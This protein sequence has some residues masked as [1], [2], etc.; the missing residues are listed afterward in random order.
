MQNTGF[1]GFGGGS[2]GGQ[3]IQYALPRVS[4]GDFSVQ[5]THGFAKHFGQPQGV[6]FDLN[7]S[8][9]LYYNTNG[10]SNSGK[11]FAEKALDAWS[12]VTGI[13]FVASNSS[14]ADIRFAQSDTSGAYAVTYINGSND[15]V[16]A[17]V[18]IPSWWIS[19]DD[20][21]LNSYSYQTYLHE[22]GHA[23][24]LGHAGNYN[25]S[26]TFPQDAKFA[27]DSWQM[28]V[29][30]YFSQTENPNVN[31]SHAYVL[32]PMAADII[33]MHRLYGQP[34]GSDRVNTGNTIWGRDSNA[35]GPASEFS[36]LLP[37]M[38][39]TIYDQGGI[40]TVDFSNTGKNQNIDLRPG[41][42]S[43]VYGKANNV[44]IE[45]ATFIENA[46]GGSGADKIIGNAF[47][48]QLMGGAGS[49]S[50]FGL[51]GADRLFGD[52]GWDVIKGGNGSDTIYG[53]DGN[54][55]LFGEQGND[56]VQGGDG[57]DKIYGGFGIDE[58]RGGAGSDAIYGQHDVDTIF[59]DTGWDIIRGGNGSDTIYGGDGNDALLGERG[60]DV[61]H[62]GEGDDKILG[63]FDNDT[64]RGD[65]GAD[66]IYGEHGIDTIYGGADRDLISGGGGADR[67][68][69][70]DGNDALIGNSGNDLISGGDGDD[71]MAGGNGRDV[72]RGGAGND[73]LNGEASGDR[74]NGGLGH[75]VLIG[76]PGGDTF[77][78]NDGDDVIWDFSDAQGDLLEIDSSLVSTSNVASFLASNAVSNGN[79]T[80][81]TFDN[82]DTLTLLG[83]TDPNALVDDIFFF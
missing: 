35:E 21:N 4:P 10:I 60:H 7:A 26:A 34:S 33:A 17:D 83:L 55:A 66:R 24:G 74:L 30:S 9:T 41:Y 52:Q 48:N 73:R 1:L 67:I 14:F 27:N 64:L 18:N 57:K 53:Q 59:G 2:A 19:G 82:G 69:G 62:G 25:G 61:I 23:L 68:Y 44:H 71:L 51:H 54:D 56:V 78:F 65:A 28:S 80:T 58:L 3:Q 63:G 45:R 76:G 8:R 81:I 75:D 39:M 15:I 31:A 29:M 36:S 47:A 5:L 70:D 6:S 79:N 46:T 37:A 32:T 12:A 43:S 77:I 20:Y 13:A 50:I 11:W 72:L 16:R 49:D 22:I 40:D 42:F 38:T